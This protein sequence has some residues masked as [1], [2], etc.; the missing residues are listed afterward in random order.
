MRLLLI[1]HGRMG[2]LV[3]ALAPEYLASI[4]GVVTSRMR[5]WRCVTRDFGPVDV[6]IDFSAG[7]T[8][9]RRRCRILAARGINVVIG[10]TGWAARE[11]ELRETRGAIAR[12]ACSPRRT[13]RSGMNLF[14]LIV[15]H[16]ANRFAGHRRSAR[17]FT[18][19][20]TRRRRTRRPARRCSWRPAWSGAG[21]APSDRRVVDARRLDSRHAHGRLRRPIRD[22]R[23]SR[24]PSATAPS[25]RAAPSKPRAG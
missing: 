4:A 22:R 20:T 3:E 5:Q 15:E 14:Q 12:S 10:T 1:G 19:C 11:A 17:G 18:S 9:C 13:S 2:K 21:Y 23:H 25:S 16:S 8:R 24:T 7:A 6:A